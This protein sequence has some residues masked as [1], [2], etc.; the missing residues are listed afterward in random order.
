MALFDVNRALRAVQSLSAS[1]N[2]SE[3]DLLEILHQLPLP[4]KWNS[5]ALESALLSGWGKV[6]SEMMRLLRKHNPILSP[7]VVIQS[8][9]DACSSRHYEVLKYII[10]G[11]E[12]R[13]SE[14]KDKDVAKLHNA[15][16]EGQLDVMERL[17]TTN[18]VDPTIKDSNGFTPLDY[19]CLGGHLNIV[20]WLVTTAHVD[21]AK[22]GLGLLI[23][24]I[25]GGDL[26][27]IEWLVTTAHV[28]PAIKD[29]DG[30]NTLHFACGF[31]YLNI[32][33]WLVTKAHVDPT[34]EDSDGKIPLYY[35]FGKGHLHIVK[36]F[37]TSVYI[38]Q[39]IKESCGCQLLNDACNEG[40]KNKIRWLVNIA[41]IDPTVL[42]SFGLTSL[43][44]ASDMGRLDIIETLVVEL[45]VNPNIKSISG[46][47]PLH[48]AC[49]KGDLKVVEWLVNNVKCNPSIK[50]MEGLSPLMVAFNYECL[51]V[52]KY[53]I[54]RDCECDPKIPFMISAYEHCTQKSFQDLQSLKQFEDRIFTCVNDKYGSTISNPNLKVFVVGNSSAGKSTLIKAIQDKVGRNKFNY[55]AAVFRSVSGVE[56]NTAGIVPITIQ[57][58]SSGN[59]TF[60]DF[61]GQAEYYSSHAAMLKNL[62]SSPGNII[63]IVIDLSKDVVEISSALKYW[64]SFVSNLE[65]DRHTIL[66]VFTHKDAIRGKPVQKIEQVRSMTNVE[67]GLLDSGIFINCTKASSKGLDSL[68]EIII[69]RCTQF[70]NEIEVDLCTSFIFGFLHSSFSNNVALELNALTELLKTKKII[71]NLSYLLDALYTLNKQGKILFLSN[72]EDISHSWIILDT[73]VLLA[74]VNG[75]IFSPENFKQH[76]DSF[77]STGVVPLSKIAEVFSKYDVKMIVDFMSHFEFCHEIRQTEAD[78]I[79]KKTQVEDVGG[80]QGESLYFLPALVK[81][82]RPEGQIMTDEKLVYKFGWYLACSVEGD[83]LFPRFLYVLLIRLAFSFALNPDL[84]EE[85]DPSCPVM[86][87]KCNI[88][89][90]GIHWQNREGVEAV[91]EVVEQMSA[92]VVMICCKKD[93][94]LAGVRLRSEIIKTVF[95]VKEE[96]SKV[97]TTTEKFIY[98]EELKSY[99]LR[100]TTRL[101][102]FSMHELSCAI[103]EDKNHVTTKRETE[104]QNTSIRDL[105]FFEPYACLNRRILAILFDE[106]NSDSEIPGGFLSDVAGCAYQHR[107][108]FERILPHDV[109]D[110]AAA[111]TQDPSFHHNHPRQCLLILQR[112]TE[113]CPTQPVT[114]RALREVLD[115]YSFFSGRNPLESESP[116]FKMFI[117]S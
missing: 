63:L 93:T 52:V 61:A 90:N 11:G 113:Y 103:A 94:E 26:N 105:L 116:F 77:S 34:V 79:R 5:G 39:S 115:N 62:T 47:T 111:K 58:G 15:C 100:K 67:A 102:S 41:G 85:E 1:D 112:W 10:N 21:P 110:L 117:T 54:E 83:D 18:H 29:N 65:A 9:K 114:F 2:C 60:Y 51:S 66:I 12:Y 32:T 109:H 89:K 98:P 74:E 84:E 4:D 23:A 73:K 64:Y 80:S 75:T 3:D 44:I 72:K 8:V 91:V 81:T 71:I 27:I 55:L 28:D 48:V 6:V 30:W 104:L 99:P 37:F 78:L 68:Y 17:V 108:I 95:Q 70:H 36:W 46:W 96:H 92:V 59:V 7:K 69:K 13:S 38:H 88:W 106:S 20:E 16:L 87:M 76:Y 50:D 31:G 107:D 35:A 33:E 86:R 97:V 49:K 53:L 19:A 56:L 42:D 45:H 57:F 43:H 24:C 82:E 101:L 40:Y 14:I 25:I 22:D